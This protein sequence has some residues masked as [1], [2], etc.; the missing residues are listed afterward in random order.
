MIVWHLKRAIE[1]LLVVFELYVHKLD[2]ESL[3][4]L[5]NKVLTDMGHEQLIDITRRF[6]ENRKKVGHSDYY[7]AIRE[8]HLE[9]Y[10][11]YYNK[12]K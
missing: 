1:R 5:R 10:K 3:F 8:N 12:N 6:E 4:L 2:I 9:H 11:K 7:G